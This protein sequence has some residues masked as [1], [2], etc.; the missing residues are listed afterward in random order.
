[1]GGSR[2]KIWLGIP[3]QDFSRQRTLPKHHCIREEEVP[4]TGIWSSSMRLKPWA[5]FTRQLPGLQQFVLRV[6]TCTG[7]LLAPVTQAGCSGRKVNT[8]ATV[9]YKRLILSTHKT[10]FIQQRFKA[11]VHPVYMEQ[12]VKLNSVTFALSNN[13]KNYQEFVQSLHPAAPDVF[14][15]CLVCMAPGHLVSRWSMLPETTWAHTVWLVVTSVVFVSKHTG[16]RC[17]G[18]TERN[19][20]PNIKK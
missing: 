4:L 1:M 16:R 5:G 17:L 8:Q 14:W 18:L 2:G 12:G 9:L 13:G 15:L 11:L 7:R 19:I 10:P 6:A 3:L 20:L